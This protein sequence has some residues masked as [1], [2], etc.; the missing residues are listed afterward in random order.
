[1]CK[2]MFVLTEGVDS[3][4]QQ[5]QAGEEGHVALHHQPVLL[6][7]EEHSRGREVVGVLAPVLSGAR[8][9]EH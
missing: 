5:A 7:A 8:G 6:L 9:V 2:E 3:E 1:M 4:A